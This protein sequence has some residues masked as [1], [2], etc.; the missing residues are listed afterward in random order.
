MAFTSSQLEIALKYDFTVSPKVFY[1]KDTTNYTGVTYSNLAGNLT[2]TAPDGTQ[3]HSNTNFASPDLSAAG[4]FS[5]SFPL[6]LV[7]GV[8]PTGL[9]SFVYEVRLNNE[10]QSL[11]IASNDPAAKTITIN[12]NYVSS[13]LDG[14]ALAFQVVDLAT[15]SVTV[16]GAVYSAG[17]TVVTI[18]QTLP[19]LT[20]GALFQYTVDTVYTKSFQQEYSYE[21]P[22]VCINW[23]DD[24]CC[25]SMDITDVTIYPAG[26]TIVRSHTVSYPKGIVPA[27]ADIPSALQAVPT[28]SP[29]WTG[30][31][32]DVFT[33]SIDTTSG[34]I[35][36][37]DAIKGVKEHK[38]SSSQGLCQIYTC[39]G[40]MATKYAT[41]LVTAP[42][43]AAE[44]EQF[45]AQASVAYMAYTVGKQCGE[46]DYEKYLDIITSIAADCD[47]G[48][49]C[50]DCADGTPVQV[51]GCCGAVGA[52]T[53][54]ILIQSTG[55]SIV[56]SSTTNP[57]GTETTFEI[58]VSSSWFATNFNN[59]FVTKSIDGLADVNTG[60]IAEAV[61]QVLYWNDGT[62]LWER[63]VLELTQLGD[64]DVT[65][66]VDGYVL[67]YDLA[68]DTFKFKNVA[69]AVSIAACTDVTLTTL[70]N[71]DILQWDSGTSKWINVDNFLSLLTDVN[72]AGIAD[73]SALEWDTAT[74]KWI[75]FSPKKTLAS[76]DDVNFPILVDNLQR[77]QYF[78]G[79]GWTN[80]PLP[81]FASGLITFSSGFG[82]TVPGYHGFGYALD[83]TTNIVTLRGAISNSNP[84]IAPGPVT[85]CNLP[86]GIRP[87]QV[88]PFQ[89]I[90]GGGSTNAIA[91]GEVQTDG[92]VVITYYM[93]PANPST[94][95]I[96]G[97]PTG[98]I[99]IASLIQYYH[100][101]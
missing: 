18:S 25:S 3:F 42:K 58:G 27:K 72:T 94:G 48:C 21:T 67:Y 74:S 100:T 16:L 89:C 30:T 73:G 87:Q 52:S 43:R 33:A 95:M 57:A 70:A 49:D 76:L 93:S 101:I 44:M 90:V 34:L 39:L 46:A 23:T 7:A 66:L 86:F 85:L 59:Q 60:N 62:N 69:T 17:V 88:I 38:V 53:K 75:I 19:V 8:V 64:V 99:L 84:A 68:T 13:I 35:Q 82:A 10:L 79:T 98:S 83:T 22:S 65:G 78:T 14:S 91:I 4:V 29:I 81:S 50:E 24:Q 55:G 45:I 12:G 63:K 37:L 96:S 61:N 71:K 97:L 40:N 32:T 15:T 11:D 77:F 80:V 54:T 36:T 47:C 2:A 1:V 41:L 6:P 5:S 28:I 9:Y 56:V 20:G 31:W 51:V 26:A 92:D